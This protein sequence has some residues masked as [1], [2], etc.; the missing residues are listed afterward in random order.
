MHIAVSTLKITRFPKCE[1]K[2]DRMS[3]NSLLQGSLTEG[4]HI[5]PKRCRRD[6]RYLSL[7]WRVGVLKGAYMLSPNTC[8]TQFTFE[9]NECVKHVHA[10]NERSHISCS[11]PAISPAA[12]RQS[13]DL[14]RCPFLGNFTKTNLYNLSTTSYLTFNA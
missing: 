8:K 2:V 11:A 1:E 13:H 9:D 14:W 10:F 6:G 7:R 12:H 3:Q 5:V 4:A